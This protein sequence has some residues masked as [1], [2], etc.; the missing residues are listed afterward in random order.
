MNSNNKPSEFFNSDLVQSVRNSIINNQINKNCTNCFKI[1]QQGFTST[2]QEAIEHYKKYSINNLPPGE[3]EY[4]DLRYNNLCNFSC[5]TCEPAFSSSIANEILQHD[6]TKKFYRINSKSNTY[7]DIVDDLSKILATVKRINFTGGEPLL[8]KDNLK[9]LKQLLNN[10]NTDC[11]IL[12][13]TNASVI[14]HH[15]ISLLKEFKNVHWTVSIDGVSSFAEYIRHGTNWA[16]VSR[17]IDK[18]V[19]LKHSVA[20]NTV[21]SAYSVLD[22]DTLVKFFIELK[23]H[24]RGPLEHWFHICTFPTY[25]NPSVLND[26][27]SRIASIKL[28][29]AVKL[30]STVTDNPKISIQTLENCVK[31]L[32]TSNQSLRLQF[33]EFT[34]T[35]DSIRKQNFDSLVQG[36]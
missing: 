24:A 20:F 7:N 10:N 21:L 36:L 28:E 6:S 1:E 32:N 30:L 35:L 4:L 2:R 11:E 29:N 22:I 13:T 34:N 17:N 27:L 18:I 3:I 15:W 31:I 12:I 9:V 5:R 33:F 8:V 23:K 26:K 16:V 14:N 19:S 25:L